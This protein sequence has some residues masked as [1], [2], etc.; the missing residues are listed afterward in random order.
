[1][2]S[3]RRKLELIVLATGTVA[4]PLVSRATTATW[5]GGATSTNWDAVGAWN[6]STPN[7]VGD[8]AVFNTAGAI[9][10]L[11]LGVTLGELDLNANTTINGPDT[12][13]MES[14]D[15]TSPGILPAI[16]LTG[17]GTTDTISAPIAYL[18]NNGVTAA[19]FVLDGI[20]GVSGTTLNINGGMTGNGGAISFQ[21]G[22]F[23][24]GTGSVF[25]TTNAGAIFVG[26]IGETAVLNLTSNV[27]D[28]GTF[29]LGEEETL[30]TSAPGTGTVNQSS[31]AVTTSGTVRI[32]SGFIIGSA[33]YI[34]G[35]TAG[36]GTYN[37]TGGSLATGSA[38]NIVVGSQTGTGYLN[39]SGASTT[40]T[41]GGE[42]T[43]GNTAG[44]NPGQGGSG[45]VSVTD[46]KF[47]VNNSGT[48][49][50]VAIGQV[51][52]T[53]PSTVLV[54]G[55][56]ASTGGQFIVTNGAL[57]IGSQT[58]GNASTTADDAAGCVCTFTIEDNSVTTVGSS[59]TVGGSV[60][61]FGFT[62]PN[63]ATV[64]IS[65]T[66]TSYSSKLSVGTSLSIG[67]GGGVGTFI[68]NESDTVPINIGSAT[69]AG[70]ISVGSGGF[71]TNLAGATYNGGNGS[72]ALQGKTVM[73]LNSNV[74]AATTVLTVGSSAAN[75][76]AV[77]TNL[78]SIGSMTLSNTAVL[79]IDTTGNAN[80]LN[81]VIGSGVAN[82]QGDVG[83]G[84]L[85][86]QN[87]SQLNLTTGN[88]TVG[89]NE[90]SGTLNIGD[91][92]AITLLAATASLVVGT[93]SNSSTG[94]PVASL[95]Q[96]GT[97]LITAPSVL[98]GNGV[99][100]SATVS[101]GTLDATT[102]GITLGTST[103]AGGTAAT[104]GNGT[105]TVTG[106]TAETGGGGNVVLCAA[107][108][109]F[110]SE[111]GTLNLQGGLLSISGALQSNNTGV[112]ANAVVNFTGG[113]LQVAT[114][115]TTNFVSAVS[116]TALPVAL[117]QTSNAL[118]QTNTNG[119][120]LLHAATQNLN[121]S[122]GYVLLGGTVQADS[123]HT[124]SVSGLTSVNTGTIQGAGTFSTS[125]TSGFGINGTLTVSGPGIVNLNG[126]SLNQ[127]ASAL[128]VT[129]GTVN[130]SVAS[131]PPP[132]VAIS[133]SGLVHLAD[134]ISAGTPLGT[135]NVNLTSLSI[136][137]SGVL[138]IGNNRIIVDYSSPATDPIASINSWIKNGF[139]DLAGPQIISSDIAADDLASGLSYGIGYADGADGAV[140]GLP[141]GEIEVMFTLLGDANLDGIVNSED[142]TPFSANVG[143]NGS[144]DNGDFNYDGT[145]NSEDFTPFSANL[146]QSATLAAA[147]GVLEGANGLSLANV[148]EPASIGLMALGA[149]GVLA[150]RRRYKPTNG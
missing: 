1:M 14:T 65:G 23:D 32:G 36:L 28:G 80:A 100:G 116:Q 131:L 3:F 42:L 128:A 41:A 27:S 106:G 37:L 112:P 110:A 44:V 6:P 145:V 49:T 21:S 149:V 53:A 130:V 82:N 61:S 101:G 7:A 43:V 72:L 25:S 77:G 66:A 119:A 104:I 147:A 95:L 85:T 20:S 113:E 45:T 83:S 120:S 35:V 125:A 143:K 146:G 52:P 26:N 98:I 99:N 13:T 5:A 87:N 63:T 136:T 107:A 124:I 109:V 15:G 71:F 19:R 126:P 137:G 81:V 89:S 50:A 38:I 48:G 91:S 16:N 73:N 96:S 39:L 108:S 11:D 117:Q 67:T 30:D 135:S 78:G 56:S 139:Y 34:P 132:T 114:V 129:G 46:G 33:S 2:R 141:S 118:V 142:F 40:V 127:A 148:P 8:D 88:L 12:L 60:P 79:N 74:T 55:S 17:S 4:L 115:T 51:N 150:R 22:N 134:N 94:S 84:T 9:A 57:S 31:G 76:V 102:G 62:S 122:G 92:A 59:M 111:E 90:T 86:M 133:G 47:T 68:A 93:H 123:G 18:F 64:S 121:I 138:D 58:I 24:Q 97:S 70:A 103:G 54:S 105:L 29:I 144:W 69:S 75:T 10:N 140:A